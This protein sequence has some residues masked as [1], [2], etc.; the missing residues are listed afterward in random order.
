[1]VA[2]RARKE[3]MARERKS[4]KG[5]EQEKDRELCG[6]EEKEQQ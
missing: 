3:I 5:R 2:I 1:M 6:R 4:A